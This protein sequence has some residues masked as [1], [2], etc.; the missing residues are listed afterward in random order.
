[1]LNNQTIYFLGSIYFL[2]PFSHSHVW[3]HIISPQTSRYHSSLSPSTVITSHFIEKTEINRTEQISATSIHQC[4]IYSHILLPSLTICVPISFPI[5]PLV[6]WRFHSSHKR[7]LSIFP[8]LF[9]LFKLIP[10]S[11]KHA[12]ILSQNTT[13]CICLTPLSTQANAM[14]LPLTIQEK[15]FHFLSHTSWNPLQQTFK[16]N[17]SPETSFNKI[18]N[19][20]V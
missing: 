14:F 10:I 9:F 13:S 16:S 7:T 11:M 1:M 20:I 8:Y 5:T 12:I 3:V 2:V 4:V 19:N 18:T 6:F 17:H 15:K